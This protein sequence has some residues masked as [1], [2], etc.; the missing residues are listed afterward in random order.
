M[1]SSGAL[2]NIQRTV[3]YFAQGISL[4]SGTGGEAGHRVR[5]YHPSPHFDAQKQASLLRS[6]CGR[7]SS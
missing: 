2:A 1:Y 7:P 5:P 6:G 3:I 4:F